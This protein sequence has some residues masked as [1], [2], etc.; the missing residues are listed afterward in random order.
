MP[1]LPGDSESVK[2]SNIRELI[3]SGRPDKQAIAIAL[4]E[5]RRTG[6]GKKPKRKK[7]RLRFSDDDHDDL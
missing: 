1:L 2:S 3:N 7:P 6:T 4:S 5:A